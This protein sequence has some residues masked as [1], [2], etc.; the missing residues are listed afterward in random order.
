MPWLVETQMSPESIGESAE[1][2][3]RIW[4]GRSAVTQE[5]LSSFIMADTENCTGC[6]SCEI[7]CALAHSGAESPKVAGAVKTKLQPRLYAVLAEDVSAVI[8]CRHCEDAPCA[9][10]CKASAIKR[11]EGRVEVD[12][13]LCIGCRLCLMACPFG[14][15]EFTSEDSRADRLLV[16]QS[17]SPRQ[18]K[19]AWRASKCDLCKNQPSGPACVQNCPEKALRLVD[20]TSAI[21]RR[22]TD[23]VL[24]LGVPNADWGEPE[25]SELLDA[26][27]VIQE[28]RTRAALT[29][30]NK[31]NETRDLRG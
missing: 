30:L 22:K 13:R 19:T 2:L 15:I 26:V 10:V 27:A 20:A 4:L 25:D 11:I 18:T 8:V 12:P 28:R 6:R 5:R 24:Q 3:E 7:A 17:A 1:V 14:A 31:Q 23:A 29:Y 9:N 16:A 21:A